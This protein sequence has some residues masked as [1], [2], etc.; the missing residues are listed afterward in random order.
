MSKKTYYLT[1][2]MSAD[3]VRNSAEGM[4]KAELIEAQHLCE[5]EMS[6]WDEA[7]DVVTYHLTL[8][9]EEE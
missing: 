9:E 4:T 5:L 7:L 8:M 3:D 2:T 1:A 6:F